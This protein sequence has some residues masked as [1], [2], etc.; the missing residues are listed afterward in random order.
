MSIVTRSATL[1]YSTTDR[2]TLVATAQRLLPDPTELGPI[3]LVGVGLTS[4]SDVRQ[5]SLFPE[6]EREREPETEPGSEPAAVDQPE[7]AMSH[8]AGRD[9]LHDEH[10]FGWV[11][12]TGHGVLTI[13][14]ETRTSGPG[15]TRTVR[16]D[17]PAL[18][19]ADAELSLR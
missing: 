2:E 14:F 5:G 1:P 15:P 13:R 17:D 8:S 10:G 7:E 4:L 19:P 12:G 3:R 18:H 11:Q 16:I 9:V 6:L